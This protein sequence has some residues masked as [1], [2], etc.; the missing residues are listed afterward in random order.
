MAEEKSSPSSIARLAD[1]K[2]SQEQFVEDVNSLLGKEASYHRLRDICY[3]H[4]QEGELR[5]DTLTLAKG[6]FRLRLGERVARAVLDR[7]LENLQDGHYAMFTGDG[8]VTFAL[9][10][11]PDSMKFRWDEV[12]E[13]LLE[14][15]VDGPG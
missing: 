15:R 1:V 13:A 10:S 6:F 11:L 4:M 2:Q 12:R 8:G 9:S 5:Q 3:R 14:A 7:I